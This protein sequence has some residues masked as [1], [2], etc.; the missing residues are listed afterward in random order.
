M[1][2]QNI[3]HLIDA[4]TVLVGALSFSGIAAYMIHTVFKDK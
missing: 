1:T 3:N 4:V 2:P